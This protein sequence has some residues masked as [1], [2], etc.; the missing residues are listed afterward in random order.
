LCINH[1]IV[2]RQ[3]SGVHRCT[4][5]DLKVQLL[6]GDS[7]WSLGCH[8]TTSRKSRDI[9]LVVDLEMIRKIGRGSEK[10]LNMNT[11]PHHIV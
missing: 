9:Y 4:W 11:V 3:S 2:G 7:Q 5:S 6:R 10:L 1:N 8:C